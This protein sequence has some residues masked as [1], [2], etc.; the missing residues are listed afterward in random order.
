MTLNPADMGNTTNN[1]IGRSQWEH[2]PYLNGDIDK[3]YIYNRALSASEVSDLYNDS[4]GSTPTPTP[5]P[6]PSPGDL[7]D[8]N[9]DGAIDIV[10]ALLIAQYY[11]GLDPVTFIPGNADT[12]CDGTIDIL[13]ALLVA[14][15]Y[16]GLLSAF[17]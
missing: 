9:G 12:N 4:P 8:V 15:F 3:F 13:D 7:G 16:V 1:F 2:D 6:T 5:D 17:C 14:Q 11:V 10:D